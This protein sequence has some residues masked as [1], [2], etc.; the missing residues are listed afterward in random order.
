MNDDTPTTE[1]KARSIVGFCEA[2]SI[3]RSQF[4]K[5]DKQGKAP[6][7]THTLGKPLIFAEDEAR[8]L[9]EIAAK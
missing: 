8:W 6:R 5:L 9:V 2:Y 4:Y 1:P 7:V 3:S